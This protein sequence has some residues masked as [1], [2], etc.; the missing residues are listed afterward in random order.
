VLALGNDGDTTGVVV[1]DPLRARVIRSYSFSGWPEAYGRTSDSLVFLLAAP[2]QIGATR[3]VITRATGRPRL[4]TL[5]R[6]LSGYEFPTDADG[7]FVGIGRRRLP[8]LA[9]D[10]VADRAYVVGGEA[11]IA[12]VDL[13]RAAV[14]Y[15]DLSTP[16]SLLG[17]LDNWLEPAA[18]A[19]GPIDGPWRSARWLGN[20]LI[21]VSGTNETSTGANSG[22]VTP[23]GLSLIDTSTWTVRMLDPN[24]M[25]FSFAD[26]L[27]LAYSDIGAS[28]PPEAAPTPT[29]LTAYSLDG[30]QRFH[31]FGSAPISLLDAVGNLAYTSPDS[32]GTD[33]IDLDRGQ[34]IRQTRGRVS[35]LLTSDMS[36]G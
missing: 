22:S 15:H 31:L 13:R 33:V 25:R 8:G 28:P 30:S 16:V 23:A 21:A 24:P 34:V 20:G 36:I 2:N 35:T 12:Q 11:Q 1:V 26:G 14:S 27:L 7:N 6:I 32:R 3:L 5:D 9:L 17:R 29:G 4:L 10:P 18:L 19:K